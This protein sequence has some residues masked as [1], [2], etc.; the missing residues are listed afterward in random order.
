MKTNAT[1]AVGVAANVDANSAADADGTQLSLYGIIPS[2]RAGV[3]LAQAGLQSIAFGELCAVVEQAL[4][5]ARLASGPWT[6]ADLAALAALAARHMAVLQE[7]MQHSAVVP[8]HIGAVFSSA[9]AVAQTLAQ[10]SSAFGDLLARF[11]GCEEWA[12]HLRVDRE[13]QQRLLGSGDAELERLE[14][15]AA[16]AG[17]GSAYLF[18]RMSEARREALVN[19]QIDAA[20]DCAFDQLDGLIR[21]TVLLAARAPEPGQ[22]ASVLSVALLVPIVDRAE[23]HLRLQ[24]LQAELGAE[25]FEVEW[26]G[27]WPPYSFCDMASQDVEPS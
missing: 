21:E 15:A 16:A 18:A 12:I 20:T 2:D 10:Q 11:A 22:L 23:L 3:W 8:A 7:V 25:G 19:E 9:L 27:P 26:T 24:A 13:G 4:P 1:D 14:R 6:D 5:P 17:P